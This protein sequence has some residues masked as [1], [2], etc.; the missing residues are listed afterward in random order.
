[1]GLAA[2]LGACEPAAPVLAPPEPFRAPEGV[3]RAVAKAIE[4]ARAASEAA[5][6][7]RAARLDL[8]RTYLANGFP[9]PA[10]TEARSIL[11]A[12]AGNAHA[13]F[14]RALAED[15]AGDRAAA[16]DSLA[17][18]R[19]L[20][21][22]LSAAAWRAAYWHL[23]DGELEPARELFARAL[24][25]EPRHPLASLGAARAAL[26]DGD[27]AAAIALL[28]ATATAISTS[29]S[30]R[31]RRRAARAAGSSATTAGFASPT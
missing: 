20:E 5:P 3:P 16:L 8:A 15:A 4:G 14:V 10:I 11:D 18:V 7:D 30:C 19:E 23:D 9:R 12:D 17:R 28:E 29:T 26:E 13:W 31:A 24:A 2:A 25:I 22:G 1:L 6:D 21:P 27:A